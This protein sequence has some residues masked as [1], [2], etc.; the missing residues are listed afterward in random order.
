[1]HERFSTNTTAVCRSSSHGRRCSVDSLVPQEEEEGSST[2]REEAMVALLV[3]A[4]EG[5]GIQRRSADRRTANATV[6]ARSDTLAIYA[7]PTTRREGRYRTGGK[8]D[9]T[10]RRRIRTV[11]H[12]NP[13]PPRRRLHPTHPR[14][15]R[16]TKKIGIAPTTTASTRTWWGARCANTA[17]H[18]G[19]KC[20]LPP[21]R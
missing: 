13:T 5:R 1:M 19:R 12:P 11:L 6:A 2:R 7:R 16:R 18:R 4:A 17:T 20:H 10:R 9:R 15:R 8:H 14:R 21:P 3:D